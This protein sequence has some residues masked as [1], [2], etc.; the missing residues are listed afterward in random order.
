MA[1]RLDELGAP[2]IDQRTAT[3]DARR[4]EN[5]AAVVESA[6]QMS[7]IDEN[8]TSYDTERKRTFSVSS[9]EEEDVGRDIT[10]TVL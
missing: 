5:A 9:N 3:Y 6:E 8:L 4:A 1:W 2:P 7:F 10:D